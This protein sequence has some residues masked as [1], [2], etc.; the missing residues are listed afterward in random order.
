MADKQ[1]PEFK[2]HKKRDGLLVNGPT[3]SDF[4]SMIEGLVYRLTGRIPKRLLSSLGRQLPRRP[5]G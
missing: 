2:V 1:S 5:K 4:M 3:G